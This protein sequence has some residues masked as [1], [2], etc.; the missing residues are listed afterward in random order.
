MRGRRLLVGLTVIF[1]LAGCA[2]P[3]TPRFETS[4]LRP[5]DPERAVAG[6][7]VFRGDAVLWGG[8]IANVDV[9]DSG[10]EL[11]ILRYP[12]AADQRP[13]T[14]AEAGRRFIARFPDRLD[15]QRYRRQRRITVRGTL[16]GVVEGSVGDYPYTY[17]F[18]RATDHELWPEAQPSRRERDQP[19]IRF[20]VG[21]GIRIN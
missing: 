16:D 15:P 9:G 12:L 7:D 18:V 13:D 5:L 19:R 6:A 14:D 20:G 1:A 4:E 3:G 8:R 2:G 17:P 11:A 21:V 10:T